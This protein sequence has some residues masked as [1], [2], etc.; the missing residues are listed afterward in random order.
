LFEQALGESQTRWCGPRSALSTSARP[1]RP[2]IRIFP[3]AGLL[4]LAKREKLAKGGTFMGSSEPQSV[5]ITCAQIAIMPR[6]SAS[7]A[8]AAAS[9][10]T[11]RNIASSMG[12]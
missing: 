7:E 1:R 6:N 5:A 8:S 11:E 9:S 10:K 4:E 2:V 12:T 3:R